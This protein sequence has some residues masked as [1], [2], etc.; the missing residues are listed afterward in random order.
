[1]SLFIDTTGNSNLGIG[2]CDRCRTKRALVDLK[3]DGNR[4]GLVVCEDCSDELDPYYLPP[5]R[6]E[7]IHLPFVRPDEPLD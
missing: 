5:R 7:S 3:P 2:I 6:A 4:T 1:M